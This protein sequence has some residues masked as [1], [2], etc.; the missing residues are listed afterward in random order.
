MVDT[1]TVRRGY[2]EV[3]GAFAARR[4]VDDQERAIVEGFLASLP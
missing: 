3:A 2:D 4:S 1:D